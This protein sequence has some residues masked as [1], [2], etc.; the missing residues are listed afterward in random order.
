MPFS[1]HGLLGPCPSRSMPFSVHA[2]LGPCP[3]RSV[4]FS[5]R[6]LLGPCR[7]RSVSFSVRALPR[8]LPFFRLFLLNIDLTTSRP[9]SF[10]PNRLGL[11]TPRPSDLPN[12]PPRPP[13]IGPS[14]E[15]ASDPSIRSL[16][17][18]GRGW[19]RPRSRPHRRGAGWPPLPR[20]NNDFRDPNSSA[21]SSTGWFA[22]SYMY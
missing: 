6:A 1:V 20:R 16:G 4:P 19:P 21:A 3:S 14:F 9:F 18:R 12:C 7:S 8:P 17:A 5:V 11:R 13:P 2:L 15:A 10:L 22:N